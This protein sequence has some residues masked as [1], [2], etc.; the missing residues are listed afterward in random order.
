MLIERP[1]EFYEGFVDPDDESIEPVYIDLKCNS[2]SYTYSVEGIECWDSEYVKYG[3]NIP[4][5]DYL[6]EQRQDANPCFVCAGLLR[7]VDKAMRMQYVSPDLI[8]L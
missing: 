1:L 2:S 8:A 7:F 6:G 5:H 3:S 4:L